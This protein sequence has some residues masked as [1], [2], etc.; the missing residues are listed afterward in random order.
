[1]VCDRHSWN[2]RSVAVCYTSQ[3]MILIG[4]IEDTV[5]VT[6]ENKRR[7]SDSLTLQ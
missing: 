1:M 5:L 4:T 3:K 7:T 2:T 6:P